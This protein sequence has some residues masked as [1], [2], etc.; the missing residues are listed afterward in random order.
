MAR[1]GRVSVVVGLDPAGARGNPAFSFSTSQWPQLFDPTVD[2]IQDQSEPEILQI[3]G[4]KPDASTNLPGREPMDAASQ[5]F[6]VSA[7]FHPERSP[8]AVA[9]IMAHAA[10]SSKALDS[11]PPSP[12]VPVL[13]ARCP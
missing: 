2:D 10:L 12:N 6:A 7:I 9:T 13:T 11:P 4:D 8:R 3:L 1:E 5:R